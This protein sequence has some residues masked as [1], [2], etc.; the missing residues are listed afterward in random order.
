MPPTKAHLFPHRVLT[1][2]ATETQVAQG[3][4]QQE[5]GP[6]ANRTARPTSLLKM[7]M[8]RPGPVESE[9]AF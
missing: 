3:L 6:G 4:K 8:L 7:Q 2:V 9:S 1:E 5:C